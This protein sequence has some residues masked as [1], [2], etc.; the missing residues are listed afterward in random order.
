MGTPLVSIVLPTYNRAAWLG[1][2]IASVRAQSWQEWELLIVDDGST[3]DTAQSLPADQRIRLVSRP[4]TG[5]L[6]AVRNAGLDAARGDFIGFLDSDDR[7]RPDKLTRQVA[8]LKARQDCGWCYGA[9]ALIDVDGHTSLPMRAGAPWIPREGDLFAAALLAEAG[10][11]IVTVL[12]RCAD[13]LA[14]RFDERIPWGDDYDF[15]VRL[16][17]HAHGCV[18]DDVVAEVRDHAERGSRGPRRSQTHIG[19]I[20]AMRKCW[21]WLTDKDLRHA[22]RRRA[23]VETRHFLANARAARALR[24]GLRQLATAWWPNFAEAVSAGRAKCRSKR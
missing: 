1:D 20:R 12:V 19:Q 11:S 5:N 8:Q 4:H 7:W 24:P 16:A 9:H 18:V 2:A 3:D 21:P 10:I 14:I 6:A 22:A 23:I 13:A 17:H 15:V